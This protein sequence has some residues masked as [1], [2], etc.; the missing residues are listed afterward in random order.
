MKV[1]V[2][3]EFVKGAEEGFRVVLNILPTLIGL[4]VGIGMLRASQ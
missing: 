2:Y 4:M 1:S 3:D